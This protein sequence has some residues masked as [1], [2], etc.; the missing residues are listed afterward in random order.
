[1]GRQEEGCIYKGDEEE[2]ERRRRWD[3]KR[4]R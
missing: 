3:G 1:M 2:I 4:R